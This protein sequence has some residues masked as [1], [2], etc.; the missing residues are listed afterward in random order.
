MLDIIL[1]DRKWIYNVGI[2]LFLWNNCGL[3]HL[4]NRVFYNNRLT[5]SKNIAKTFQCR[6]QI[7]YYCKIS[8]VLN[9]GYLIFFYVAEI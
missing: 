1:V 8:F 9:I 4:Y 2:L 7:K 6:A 5:M 3:F